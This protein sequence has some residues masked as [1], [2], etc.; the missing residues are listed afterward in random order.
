M[1]DRHFAIGDRVRGTY[2]RQ[3][4]TGRVK[5]IGFDTGLADV[6]RTLVVFDQPVLVTRPPLEHRR[7]RASLLLDADGESVD[8]KGRKD[9]LAAV[10]REAG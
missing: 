9:G 2:L 7:G 10:E 6:R 3:P 1:P 4:F 8:T 5:D